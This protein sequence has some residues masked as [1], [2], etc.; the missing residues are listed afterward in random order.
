MLIFIDNI[1]NIRSSSLQQL[2]KL[3][4]SVRDDGPVVTERIMWAYN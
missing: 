3:L 1:E 2:N 4:V